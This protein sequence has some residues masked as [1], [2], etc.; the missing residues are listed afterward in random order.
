MAHF[1]ITYASLHSDLDWRFNLVGPKPGG[2]I[3][4]LA[5]EDTYV[6]DLID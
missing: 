1:I 3:I 2:G 5:S 4:L 6:I